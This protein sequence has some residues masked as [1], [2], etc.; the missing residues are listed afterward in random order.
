MAKV[1]KLELPDDV[2][3]LKVLIAER[4]ERIAEHVE[5]IAR[6]EHEVKILTQAAFGPKSE[7]RP[8]GEI[9]TNL[10]QGFLLFP[11]MIEAAERVADRTAQEGTVEI[12]SAGKPK[13]KPKRR[14]QFPA[15][16]PHIRSTYELSASERTCECGNALHEIGEETSRELERLEICVVHEIARKKYACRHC[17][18]RVRTASGPGRVID[19]GILGAG[20]LAHLITERFS[21]HMPY[22]R[23]EKKYASEGIDL[24][25]S[26][27]CS[28]AG[29]CAELLEP[30]YDELVRG[31]MAGDVI[32]T[33]DTSVIVQVGSQ[34]GSRK[35]RIWA[36]LGLQ[37]EHVYHYTETREQ[38]H[39]CDFLGDW[40]GYLQA[41]ALNV[42]DVLYGEE[43][44]TEVGCW[45]HTR[46]GFVKAEE[47]E[48]EL[49]KEALRRI[50]ELYVI[51]R[52]AK[53]RELAPQARRELRQRESVP[54]LEALLDWLETT[55]PK[56][57]DKGPMGKAID[58]ALRQWQALNRYC[59]DG[60][61]EIDNNDTERALRQVAVGRKNW[62]FFGNENGGRTAA[63]LYTLVM[64]AKAVG[65]DPRLYLR[66]VLLRIAHE[67]DVT[68]LTPRGWKTHFASKVEAHRLSILERF[69]EARERP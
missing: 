22:H 62:I 67:S 66:D 36:F 14:K 47:S 49:A 18:E 68:K 15:H 31:L 26:V 39:L 48:P 23:L 24:S 57:L 16:L 7:R 5:R 27:L 44:A 58:Y 20:F 40:R 59:E 46:R 34:G 53:E 13:A 29:R 25:R 4:D 64:T 17:E 6:L 35:A 33:D 43:K 32:R 41:D 61:L 2:D 55:R 42:Y 21:H 60:R 52:M 45:A 1:T 54:R 12:T 63:I 28:S 38:K 9:D 11:E 30:I 3:A 50:G 10:L 19:K 8:R 37:D 56:V 69:L 51:E 65:I